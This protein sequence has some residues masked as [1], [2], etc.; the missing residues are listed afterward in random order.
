MMVVMID[1]VV[2]GK[3]MEDY[4][5][6]GTRIVVRIVV[7]AVDVDCSDEQKNF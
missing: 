2:V 3:T 1:R 6:V 4:D 7:T 5:G